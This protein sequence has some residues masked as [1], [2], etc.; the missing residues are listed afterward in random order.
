MNVAHVNPDPNP[1][2]TLKTKSFSTTNLM[3]P[4]IFHENKVTFNHFSINYIVFYAKFVCK[5][6]KHFVKKWPHF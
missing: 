6:L 3:L 5:I 2:S 4:V 1:G